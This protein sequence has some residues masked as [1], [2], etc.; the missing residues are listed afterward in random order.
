[1]NDITLGQV[2]G[3]Y[4][5][6]ID[7]IAMFSWKLGKKIKKVNRRCVVFTVVSTLTASVIF[8]TLQEQSERIDS[9]EKEIKE[10]KKQKG[11]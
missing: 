6:A 1:M 4:G 8:S 10:L 5:S 7:D 11:E 3:T 2:L 9:L